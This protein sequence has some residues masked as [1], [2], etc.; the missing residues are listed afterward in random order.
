MA[1]QIALLLDKF[2]KHEKDSGSVEVQVVLLTNAINELQVHCDTN[3]KDHSSSRGLM[4]KVNQRKRFLSYLRETNSE[5]YRSLVK[6]LGL[7]K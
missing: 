5:M 2:K 1:K 4:Q 7:R 6:E 3:P